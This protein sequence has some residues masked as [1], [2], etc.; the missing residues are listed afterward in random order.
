VIDS[1]LALWCE[2]AT[3]PFMGLNGKTPLIDLQT[4][5][6]NRAQQAALATNVLTVGP[7]QI[8]ARDHPLCEPINRSLA[9]DF[10]FSVT[11][12]SFDCVPSIGGSFRCATLPLARG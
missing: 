8:L 6:V 9:D 5:P 2:E 1:N 10:G 12:L 11:L 4:I 7:R 3:G